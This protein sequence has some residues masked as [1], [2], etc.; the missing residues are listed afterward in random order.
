MHRILLAVAFV[1]LTVGTAAAS[2]KTGVMATVHKFVDGFN[3]G[4][5]RMELSACTA[6]SAVIDDFP[7]HVWQGSGCANW[8][9]DYAAMTKKQGITNG[10]VTLGTPRH[11]D[12]TGDRAYVVVPTIFTFKQHGK[13][14]TESGAT[15]TLALQ[16]LASGW[17]ITGWAWA[18]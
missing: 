5:T 9:R 11:V 13:P 6:Q 14:V 8:V 1:V 18:D 12:V 16:K 2:E 15:F 3:K 4:D 7:P 10:I 17:R